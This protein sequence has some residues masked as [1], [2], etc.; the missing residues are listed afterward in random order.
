MLSVRANPLVGSFHHLMALGFEAKTLIEGVQ[1]C[2]QTEIESQQDMAIIVR[3]L[4][5]VFYDEFS[6]GLDVGER[7]EHSSG[8]VVPDD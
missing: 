4:A 6:D 1:C 2:D 8:L 3:D 7:E 5:D